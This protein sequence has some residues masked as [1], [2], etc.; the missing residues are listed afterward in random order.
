[1]RAGDGTVFNKAMEGCQRFL[2]DC[3]SPSSAS[4][5]PALPMASRAGL[6]RAL[7]SE[8]LV[9]LRRSPSVLRSARALRCVQRWGGAAGQRIGAGR[10]MA[11][12][13]AEHLD[14]HVSLG[15]AARESAELDEIV[16]RR[17]LLGARMAAASRASGAIL[18]QVTS[19]AARVAGCGADGACL[20]QLASRA[21]EL[22]R[23]GS[24]H[25]EA[26]ALFETLRPVV[27]WVDAWQTPPLFVR[28]LRSQAVWDSETLR[29]HGGGVW[30]L[31]RSMEAAFPAVLEDLQRIRRRP[32]PA[33]YGPEL[34]RRPR[35]WSKV[36]LYEGGDPPREL[37]PVLCE[38][39]APRTCG[40]LR[41]RI[42]GIR[43]ARIPYLQPAHEQVAF[44]RLARGSR[45]EFHHASQN[46]RLTMH[47]CLT[48]CDGP[49]S[50][51]QVGPR[52]FRWRRGRVVV[53]DDSYEHR[54]FMD[55]HTDRW[56]LHVMVVHPDLDSQ[57]K[58][59]A[60]LD[61]GRLWPS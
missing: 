25:A 35:N 4:D 22:L 9:A 12:T 18:A 52:S 47:M 19:P 10:Q 24:A 57:A 51:L 17:S 26:D 41:D 1:M 42:P 21:M 2:S 3:G 34:I 39:F 11:R 59:R 29:R 43:D 15:W 23:R 55:P 54:V 30:A 16:W 38:H 36:L 37:H 40:L 20:A 31:A 48:G 58:F 27:P 28:G 56:I 5:G 60:A 46:A 33:A 6:S 13:L 50:R 7:A 53:F 8:N 32:W 61:G 49:G 45:I 44:F 14:P